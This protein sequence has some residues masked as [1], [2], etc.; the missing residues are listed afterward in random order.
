MPPISKHFRQL[1][2]AWGKA[3]GC[4]EAGNTAWCCSVND[5]VVCGGWNGKGGGARFSQAPGTARLSA[6]QRPTSHTPSLLL[7]NI[8]MGNTPFIPPSR[9]SH[10][11]P[12]TIIQNTPQRQQ[13]QL[14]LQLSTRPIIHIDSAHIYTHRKKHNYDRSC[15]YVC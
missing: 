3:G 11:A 14:Y 12:R 8:K 4:L 2:A 13:L 1:K 9:P 6:K 10:L 15:T 5:R 7:H